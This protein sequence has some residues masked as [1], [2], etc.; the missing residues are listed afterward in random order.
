M[1]SVQAQLGRVVLPGLRDY[2]RAER[3]LSAAAASRDP[4]AL[5]AARFEAMRKARTAATELHHL[6]DFVLKEAPPGLPT[7]GGIEEVRAAVESHCVWLRGATP[8]GDVALLRDV[9]EAFKHHRLDRKN[10]RVTGADA[11]VACQS[12]YGK[13]SFGEG[14]FGGII[15]V[16]VTTR[17]GRER[18][19]TAVL[20]NVADAWRKLLGEPL[21]P[22][23]DFD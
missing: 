16:V 5:E 6:S 18:V 21:P 14:K 7:F 11:I 23:N 3:E 13:L 22:M 8:S 4:T 15:Q 10:S 19:L 12:G 2:W 20:Q 1:G 9:A 17:D